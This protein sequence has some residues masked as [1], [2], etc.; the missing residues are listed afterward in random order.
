MAYGIKILDVSFEANT[1]LTDE[2]FKVVELDSDGN[3]GLATAGELGLGVLQ[4]DPDDGE[5]GAVRVAGVSKVVAGATVGAGEVVEV[6]T[7]GRVIE[8][9]T[10]EGVGI[11]LEG[12]D[13]NEVITILVSHIGATV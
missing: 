10:G 2:Q 7:D 6:G 9:D 3:I 1:D 13:E 8:Q 11:C 12:G 4:N 5:A